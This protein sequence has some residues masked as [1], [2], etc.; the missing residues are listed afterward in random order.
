M[1]YR[2]DPAMVSM[3]FSASAM[4]S[5]KKSKGRASARPPELHH[6]PLGVADHLQHRRQS[7]L[8]TVE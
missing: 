4:A 8:D 7:P 1:A 2:L 3:G 5:P 6:A